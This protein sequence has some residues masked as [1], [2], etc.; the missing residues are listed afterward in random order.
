[1]KPLLR[2]FPAAHD[3][4]IGVCCYHWIRR[5][6]A[7]AS[8]IA[9]TRVNP[10]APDQHLAHWSAS[11]DWLANPDPT[12]AVTGQHRAPYHHRHFITSSSVASC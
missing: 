7:N 3:R 4:S 5:P 8:I 1:M 9:P 11:A 12:P 2:Q 10:L 6:V